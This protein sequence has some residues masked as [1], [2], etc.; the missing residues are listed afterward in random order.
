[1]IHVDPLLKI[2][3]QT[4]LGKGFDEL[5]V[6]GLDALKK[7]LPVALAQG[8]DGFEEKVE[9]A[10]EEI[11]LATIAKLGPQK[12]EAL[13]KEGVQIVFNIKK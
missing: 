8:L 1:M 5:K 9:A 12:V 10:I 2:A 4:A 6:H 11:I 13:A 7:H 3:V